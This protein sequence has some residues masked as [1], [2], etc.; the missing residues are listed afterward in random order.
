MTINSNS[1]II[2]HEGV[3]SIWP[4]PDTRRRSIPLCTPKSAEDEVGIDCTFRGDDIGKD[5]MDHAP[6][7]SGSKKNV[8][9]FLREFL[10][11]G[12]T[13]DGYL[14]TTPPDGA[15]WPSDEI[16]V[17]EFIKLFFWNDEW[18]ARCRTTPP[19]IDKQV[20]LWN[21]LAQLTR[22]HR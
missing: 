11:V 17:E 15:E 20:E 3:N 21:C 1:S 22:D 12:I 10:L 13:E 16:R 7:W 18:I 5:T 2:H 8:L 4:A 14:A 6:P 19:S 9:V